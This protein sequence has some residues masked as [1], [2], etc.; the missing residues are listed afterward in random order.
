M[1]II[2]KIYGGLKVLKARESDRHGQS[3]WLCR[4]ICGKEIIVLGNS[5]RNGNTKTCGC[6]RKICGPK[7]ATTHGLRHTK[8]YYLWTGAKRRAKQ[9][10][11]DFNIT[12]EFVIG[13]FE[14]TKVCPICK[15]QLKCGKDSRPALSSPTL[16]RL[17]PEKGYTS[18]NVYILCYRCNRLKDN[19]TS[20]EHRRIADWID[21]KI[22]FN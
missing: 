10:G 22:H 20:L 15:K 21:E 12:I 8:G 14:N 11:L 7:N 5:L 9:K 19:G 18:N 13:L 3:R 1:E 16:D 17:I 6:S 4:C 2:G